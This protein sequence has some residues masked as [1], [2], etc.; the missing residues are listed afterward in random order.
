MS[1]SEKSSN[2]RGEMRRSA[3]PVNTISVRRNKFSNNERIEYSSLTYLS[4]T[5]QTQLLAANN[6][7]Q[8]ALHG[9]GRCYVF[10]TLT[11]PGCDPAGWGF[12]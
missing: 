8:D 7:M 2:T 6:R 9:I 5:H 3:R 10:G 12:E 4:F 1:K 11:S